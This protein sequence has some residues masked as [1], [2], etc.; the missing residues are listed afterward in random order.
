MQ[1]G[2]TII[3]A[4][5][6]AGIEIPRFCYHDKLKIAGNCR[7][8]L[9][10]VEGG[11][12]K[13]VASCAMNIT[14]GMSIKTDSPM[15]K[16]AREGIMEFLLIN[17]PLDCPICDQGGECD[18]QDQ[19]I[20]YGKAKS[21][22]REEKRAVI[23]K[24]MGPLIKTHMTRCIHCTRC[25]RFIEDV[26]GTYELGSINRGENMEIIS[27][28][29]FDQ[30]KQTINVIASVNSAIT[31]ELSGNI[32]DLCP[33]GAL[34]SKP[35]AF[36][37]RSWELAHFPSIDIMDAI[38][39]NIQLD[40]RQSQ[41]MRV[42]PR[43]NDDLNE[44]W[45]SD[46]IRFSYDGL[47]QQRLDQPYIRKNGKLE[48][49]KWDEVIEHL[50]K[51]FQNHTGSEMAAIA[52]ELAECESI[53]MLKNLMTHLQCK[54]LE[55]RNDLK[56]DPENPNNYILG[57]NLNQIEEADFVLL[58][59]ANQRFDAPLLNW[60]IRKAVLNNN[61]KV[62]SVNSPLD[63][64]YKYENLGD[65]LSILSQILADD[66]AL[67]ECMKNTQK[68][69]IFLGQ[70]A[71]MRED[72]AAILQTTMQIAEK[73]GFIQENWKGFNV[74]HNSASMT[75]AL[76]MNFTSEKNLSGILA[77]I[78]EEKIK[79]L[80]LLNADEIDMSEL[81]NATVIY[82][83][84]HGD[85]GAHRADVIL[86]GCTFAEKN[87]SYV[88]LEG[89]L[90]TTTK[91]MLPPADARED[92]WILNEIAKKMDFLSFADVDELRK[93]MFETYPMLNGFEKKNEIEWKISTTDK[94]ISSEKIAHR[95][96]NFYL[97]NP[98][99]RASKTMLQCSQKLKKR[100]LD[101]E[102]KK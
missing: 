41:V 8:C 89:R 59:G 81:V 84:H 91:A 10:E 85:N 47:F 52:G 28:N 86:P 64:N 16:K 27:T 5:Q 33:V 100:I 94:Q 76:T 88:N 23:D 45:I 56:T 79:I 102:I 68:P 57:T 51:L 54:N 36:K 26:A 83:G 24:D 95:E 34:T 18:L 97:T 46:K 43:A 98:I 49:A 3:Q 93:K 25:I 1:E 15:V 32:I 44:D 58:I 66:H 19:A 101:K 69:L 96:R 20:K 74:L 61:A 73:F 11:P 82:Q 22:Y 80:F 77:K 67:C 12:P 6:E 13:P 42:L 53:F 60:R 99:A 9:V 65:D 55:C 17:H 2:L 40:C 87:S 39:S 62:F 37:A 50:V 30:N 75:A 90:Q 92:W 71:L 38:G 35:Y 70:D 31:S 4:C 21:I 14:E 63:L 29:N 78:N 72:G 7:M 48:P